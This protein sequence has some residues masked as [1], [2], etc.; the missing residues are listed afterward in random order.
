MEIEVT[1]PYNR[2]RECEDD[3]IR[4]INVWGDTYNFDIL[5]GLTYRRPNGGDI[6]C[7]VMSGGNSMIYKASIAIGVNFLG[8]M[9]LVKN[10]YNV[11][12]STDEVEI[13]Q[14]LF[15]TIIGI[16]F[17]H[18]ESS[19]ILTEFN[20]CVAEITDEHIIYSREYPYGVSRRRY[21]MTEYKK[22][23]VKKHTIKRH[24]LV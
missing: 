4:V 17:T 16:G 19:R 24:S 7:D 21:M 14:I 1:K 13:R 3:N 12:G 15:D 11:D 6:S 8:E 5:V 9:R 2:Y 20:T 18:L 10:R 23:W 22:M